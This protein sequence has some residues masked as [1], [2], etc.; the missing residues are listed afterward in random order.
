MPLRCK[1]RVASVTDPAKGE[2]WTGKKIVCAGILGKE[3]GDAEIRAA[4]PVVTLMFIV[5]DPDLAAKYQPLME[6]GYLDLPAPIE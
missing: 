3:E 6:L 1:L 2:K 4:V 5:S